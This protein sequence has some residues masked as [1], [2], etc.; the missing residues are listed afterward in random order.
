MVPTEI[1]MVL[2][3]QQKLQVQEDCRKEPPTSYRAHRASRHGFHRL[4][5]QYPSEAEAGREKP[6]LIP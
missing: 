1:A 2:T 4:L 3:G 6:R 5:Q